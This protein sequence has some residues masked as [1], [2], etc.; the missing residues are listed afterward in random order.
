MSRSFRNFLFLLFYVVLL[1]SIL[2]CGAAAHL[3][4]VFVYKNQAIY[5][6]PDDVLPDDEEILKIS[7][8]GK[9][10]PKISKETLYAMLGNLQYKYDGLLGLQLRPIFYPG[11][12]DELVPLV[13]QAMEAT[14]DKERLIIFSR[15]DPDRSVLSRA[16]KVSFLM[17]ANDEGISIVFGDIR[18]KIP[19]DDPLAED[20]WLFLPVFR[21][22]SAPRNLKIVPDSFFQFKKINGMDHYTW[23]VY[24]ADALASLQYKPFEPKKEVSETKEDVKSEGDIVLERLRKLK[25]AKDDGLITEEEYQERKKE[26]LK[27]F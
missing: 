3:K 2:S 8:P 27:E 15:F 4:K 19:I 18:D 12:L 17:Y 1:G 20:R 21:F 25:K 16:E 10:F 11:E 7:G 5:R 24:K 22:K 6:I 26:I 9:P 23:I 13:L 14:P